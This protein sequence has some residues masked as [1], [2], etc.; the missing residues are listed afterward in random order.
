MERGNAFSC[1]FFCVCVIPDVL[2]STLD[3][4]DIF[5]LLLTKAERSYNKVIAPNY[6]E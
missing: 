3:I 2:E 1:F 6:S 5:S 4:F